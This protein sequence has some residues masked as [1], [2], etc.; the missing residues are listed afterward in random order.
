[1]RPAFTLISPPFF[2]RPTGQHCG[3]PVP[4]A[5]KSL[6]RD[7]SPPGTRLKLNG[8]GWTAMAHQNIC[9]RRME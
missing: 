3:H 5:T 8:L 9:G 1:M 4:L 2:D 7:I 6:V